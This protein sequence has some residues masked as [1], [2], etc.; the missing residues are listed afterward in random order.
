MG[1]AAGLLITGCGPESLSRRSDTSSEAV[2][3]KPRG[4]V[5]VGDSLRQVRKS[6]GDPTIEFP[7]GENMIHWY[8][9]YEVTMSNKTV[10]AVTVLPAES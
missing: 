5:E 9:G 3:N 2:A 7:D 10:I 8:A 6:L 4:P 1:I